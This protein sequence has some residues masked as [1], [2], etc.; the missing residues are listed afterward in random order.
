MIN[1][2][3]NY[4]NLNISAV[5]SYKNSLDTREERELMEFWCHTK[6]IMR[7]VSRCV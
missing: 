6:D 2:Q 5:N 4:H 1:T 3:K 7:R